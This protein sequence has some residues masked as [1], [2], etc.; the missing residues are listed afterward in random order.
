MNKSNNDFFIY[1]MKMMM[2]IAPQTIK[3]DKAGEYVNIPFGGAEIGGFGTSYLRSYDFLKPAI[4]I[5]FP[6]GKF[7][8]LFCPM[9]NY[10][11]G[12]VIK[13]E[14]GERFAKLIKEKYGILLEGFVSSQGFAMKRIVIE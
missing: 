4:A 9:I 5:H 3:I 14:D 12:I 10:N 7:G 8:V 2:N 1:A 13:E 11:K 6:Q